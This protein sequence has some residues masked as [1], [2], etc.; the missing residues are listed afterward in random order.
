MIEIH[1]P[2]PRFDSL[3]VRLSNLSWSLGIGNFFSQNV[4]FAYSSGAIL[5]YRIARIM[6]P[7]LDSQC[8]PYHVYELGAGLGLLSRHV[9]DCLKSEFP[10]LYASIHIH[11]C[12]VS[13]E[14]IKQVHYWNPYQ[15]HPEK[16]SF[17]VMDCV[18]PHFEYQPSFV[19]ASYMLDSLPCRHVAAS[20]EGDSEIRVRTLF[21]ENAYAEEIS[22][23]LKGPDSDSLRQLTPQILPM[24]WEE[25]HPTPI[26]PE[27]WPK[28]EYDLYH[29]FRNTCE[30]SFHTH[31]NF[32]FEAAHSFTRI[33]QALPEASG[34]LLH[35]FGY[36]D[37]TVMQPNQHSISIYNACAFFAQY[38][39]FYEFL[40]KELGCRYH[41]TTNPQGKSQAMLLYKSQQDFG[42]LFKNTFPNLGIERIS[43]LSTLLKETK[44]EDYDATLHTHLQT[45]SK[46]EQENYFLYIGIAC[47]YLAYK[48]W[49]KA[50]QFLDKALPLHEPFSVSAYHLSGI[51]ALQ[52]EDC[53]EA[54]AFFR[55]ALIL[56]PDYDAS[57]FQ[58][59]ALIKKTPRSPRFKG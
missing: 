44:C 49:D 51:V 29:A 53:A 28:P 33:L 20:P 19:F 46:D 34:F 24:I 17:E 1:P 31:F 12:E 26:T 43:A 37:Q 38:F 47:D 35:D 30:S 45:L 16:V 15:E 7:F 6:A 36:T 4:P 59:R 48:E 57:A 56:C 25:Y 42:T 10:L 50:K 54:E 58:L 3:R 14:M 23:L 32:S 21:P 2:V 11:V 5:G 27:L 55:K 9:L 41:L 22:T 13:P 18:H 40:A 8:P 39:P 52:K